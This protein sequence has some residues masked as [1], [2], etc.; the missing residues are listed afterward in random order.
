MVG[1]VVSFDDTNSGH[2]EILVKEQNGSKIKGIVLYFDSWY[3][4]ATYPRSIIPLVH[5][6]E[7][8]LENEDIENVDVRKGT[9]E[10]EH[11]ESISKSKQEEFLRKMVPVTDED[12]HTYQEVSVNI[13]ITEK[14]TFSEIEITNI[15]GLEK[16]GEYI[17]PY[18]IER[19]LYADKLENLKKAYEY[20]G[21]VEGVVLPQT[22]IRCNITRNSDE[23][24]E[25][26]CG[27]S[28]P[29]KIFK[30]KGLDIIPIDLDDRCKEK[31]RI[32]LEF[33]AFCENND[34]AQ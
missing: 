22:M 14:G 9:Y 28:V 31:L 1:K 6:E 29:Y 34:L 26:L 11:Y 3:S 19:C 5:M 33:L 30:S 2:Y 12:T 32:A 18:V 16:E 24:I 21:S 20:Y 10:E 4:Q 8:D 23:K 13:E 25:E 15:L 7:F 27:V 17:N